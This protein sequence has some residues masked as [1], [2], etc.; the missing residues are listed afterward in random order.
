MM[1]EE[2]KRLKRGEVV[3]YGPCPKSERWRVNGMVQIWKRYPNKV[4]VPIKHG[5]YH[6]HSIT[7][8]NAGMFHRESECP[9]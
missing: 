2:V 9:F 7:E 1:V 4:R 6:Y 5:L 8:T 3:H